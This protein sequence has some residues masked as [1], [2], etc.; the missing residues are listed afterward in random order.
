[1]STADTDA[2]WKSDPFGRYELRYW[3]GSAWTA[4]VS[5]GG[6][7]ATDEPVPGD[8][9]SPPPPPPQAPEAPKPG[10]SWKDKLKSAAQQAAQQGKEL[11]E[12]GKALAAEQ[13]AARAEAAKNDPNLV[14]MG[15]KKSMGTSAI[16]MSSVQYR[17]TRD[18]VYVDSGLLG[19]TSEQVPLWAVIDIDVRQNVMQRGKNEG[20]VV[21]HLDQM[22]YA[23]AAEL[24][25]D[26]ISDPF[27]VRDLLNPLVSEARAKKQMLTQT[28]YLQHS[29]SPFG[30]VTAPAPAAPTPAG[31]PVDL[32]DQLRKLAE[33]RDQ[34]ILTDEEFALQKQRLLG[35]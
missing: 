5:S 14:W 23:G 34:G 21:L 31:P 32:A 28:Q 2:G 11:A 6:N 22:T 3:D 4:H 15:E 20:D 8:P 30:T 24:V 1:M 19:S 17:I 18:K 33:L 27:G 9:A 35:G 26:N 13:Q 29:G 25:L 7:Q 12:K 16:G 10:G